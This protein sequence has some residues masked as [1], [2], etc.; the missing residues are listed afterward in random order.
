M[1]AELHSNGRPSK[2]E[3]LNLQ[4]TLQENYEK[5]ISATKTADLTGINVKTV[6]KYFNEWHKQINEIEKSKFQDRILEARS[7]HLIVLDNQLNNLYKLQNKM[8][9]N[10]V[11]GSNING[12]R[13]NYNF[14]EILTVIKMIL[15]IM[16]RKEQLLEPLGKN[17]VT[18]SKN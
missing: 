15:E 17:V 3:Q 5:G 12:I 8:Q 11:T 10:T 1:T 2:Q 16:D 18:V 7:Q 13:H 14:R 6:C 9:E 4:K